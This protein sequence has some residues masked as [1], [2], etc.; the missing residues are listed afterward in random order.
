[1]CRHSFSFLTVLETMMRMFHLEGYSEQEIETFFD[2]EGFSFHL[3]FI[4]GVVD[5][6]MPPG[7][8]RELVEKRIRERLGV[9]ELILKLDRSGRTVE[10][11]EELCFHTG[12]CILDLVRM[13]RKEDD[14]EDISVHLYRTNMEFVQDLIFFSNIHPE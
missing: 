10:E 1:M 11:I 14:P 9:F 8:E 4:Q 3:L 5:V 13:G 12:S 7:T 6:R 2:N